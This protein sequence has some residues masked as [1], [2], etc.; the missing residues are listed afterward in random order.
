MKNMTAYLPSANVN[1]YKVFT[2]SDVQSRLDNSK[3]KGKPG[4]KP[5]N[6]GTCM[7]ELKKN[8]INMQCEPKASH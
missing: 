8:G 6:E 7:H 3:S 1:L 4:P 5:K 2:D